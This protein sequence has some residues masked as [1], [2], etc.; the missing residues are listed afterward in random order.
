MTYYIFYF[1]EGIGVLGIS[2]DGDVRLLGAM[3]CNGNIN[4]N[5]LDEKELELIGTSD[6]IFLQDAT[7]NGT[8]LR[9]R[10][11]KASILLPFGD[12]IISV[13]HLKI[14]CQR[15]GRIFA[16]W[17]KSWMLVF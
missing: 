4:F 3:K 12:K 10:L 13:A 1:R 8:K 2:S 15:I 14:F 5:P 6:D 16:H 17:K 11:L 7:H 9:N